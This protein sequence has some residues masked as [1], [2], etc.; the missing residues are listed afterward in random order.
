MVLIHG[1][2]MNSGAWEFVRPEL[3][4][5]YFIHLI[6]LPGY[7]EN[8]NITANDMEDIVD[9]IIPNI[10]DSS[11]LLGWSLGGL[12]AQAI[13]KKSHDEQSDKLKSLTLVASSPKFSQSDD[14]KHAISLE[15]LNNFSKNLQDDVEG[16]LKRFVALQFMGIKGTKDLQKALIDEI[17]V[18]SKYKTSN[19]AERD[20]VGAKRRLPEERDYKSS[21]N[22]GGGNIKTLKTAHIQALNIGLSILKDADYRENSHTFPQQWILADRDRLIPPKMINDLKLLRPNDQ[23]T[24]LDNTGH[25]PFMTHPKDFLAVVIP[26]I[27]SSK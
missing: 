6:D 2:G 10:P 22:R 4:A 19:Q 24:L 20:N 27:E 23:I 1:W 14:W 12:V 17:L 13:A 21:K 9:L 11:H 15:T 8:K 7:G 16:T 26:F 25:A 18:N 3:E 5:E